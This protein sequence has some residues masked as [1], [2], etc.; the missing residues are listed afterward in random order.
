[1]SQS[2]KYPLSIPSHLYKRIKLSGLKIKDILTNALEL[3]LKEPIYLYEV[4]YNKKSSKTYI[5][6]DS[7]D[8]GRLID[9]IHRKYIKLSYLIKAN[10]LGEFDI[11]LIGAFPKEIYCKQY[12]IFLINQALN[13]GYIVE[14]STEEYIRFV[15]ISIESQSYL[16]NR[17]NKNQFNNLFNNL[18]NMFIAL[19]NE[20][21]PNDYSTD[22][23]ELETLRVK[24]LRMIKD[25]KSKIKIPEI[26]TPNL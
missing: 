9:I 13:E 11:S 22:C 16:H 24:A 15:P 5:M 3:A 23:S 14:N 6:C 26:S 2:I 20:S 4:S 7:L 19:I 1:M 21:N 25:N 10:R 18:F 12:K 8:Q 17:L